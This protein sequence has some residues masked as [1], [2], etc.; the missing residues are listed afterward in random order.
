MFHSVLIEIKTDVGSVFQ[1]LYNVYLGIQTVERSYPSRSCQDGFFL[2]FQR[3][4][5][6]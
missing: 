1:T 3:E 5:I 4:W 2:R 6:Y